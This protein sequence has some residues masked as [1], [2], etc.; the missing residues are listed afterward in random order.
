MKHL[1][2]GIFYHRNKEFN[3][4]NL[5]NVISITLKEQ[6][7]WTDT[8]LAYNFCYPLVSSTS[9]PNNSISYQETIPIIWGITNLDLEKVFILFIIIGT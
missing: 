7:L 4:W 2:F 1:F 6:H 5:N 3:D 8:V 9:Y